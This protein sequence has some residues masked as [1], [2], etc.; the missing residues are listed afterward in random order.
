MIRWRLLLATTALLPAGVAAQAPHRDRRLAQLPDTMAGPACEWPARADSARWSTAPIP[1]LALRWAVPPGRRRRV[2]DGW[3]AA[4]MTLR[5]WTVPESGAGAPHADDEMDAWTW[6]ARPPARGER[7]PECADGCF[8][9]AGQ[10]QARLA[11][12]HAWLGWG[13]RSSGWG[14]GV[15]A[16]EL[17]AIIRRPDGQWGLVHARGKT[18]EAIAVAEYAIRSMRSQ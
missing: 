10:C 11:V 17:Y 8:H 13:S 5:A 1:A 14:P 4:D 12:G 3:T 7:P 16:A 2:A 6:L 9:L 15:D 18:D